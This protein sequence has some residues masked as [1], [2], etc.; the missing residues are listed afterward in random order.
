MHALDALGNPV[1]RA[2]LNELRRGPRIQLG[3][4]IE[5]VNGTRVTSGAEYR[6]ATRGHGVGDSMKF[7]VRRDGSVLEMTA[8][9]E[10]FDKAVPPESAV[11]PAIVRGVKVRV[12]R[13]SERNLLHL[14]EA[15]GLAVEEVADDSPLAGLL[16]RGMN[17][18]HVATPDRSK[19][20][21]VA[22]PAE[23][24]AELD[25]LAAGGGVLITGITGEPD[26]WVSFPPLP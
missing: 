8:A 17:I 19:V 16:S 22:T 23:L 20:T 6:R 18:L 7:A 11:P 12:L 15:I 9:L 4:V 1:R 26:R 5:S 2:I 14:T 24:T 21:S 13:R 3:D 10:D 25:A